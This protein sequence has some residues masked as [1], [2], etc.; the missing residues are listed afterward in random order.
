[1][2]DAGLFAELPAS[3]LER[4][5]GRYRSPSGHWVGVSGRARVIAYNTEVLSAEDLPSSIL[6]FT[7]PKWEGRL[8]WAP[9]NGSFQAWVTALRIAEGE[10]GARAWLEGIRDNGVTA[11]PNNVAIVDAVG[12][13]EIDAGFVNHYYLYRFLAE[14]GEDFPVRNY[15]TAAGDVGT[16]VNVAGAGM[17]AGTDSE[18]E[19]NELLEFLLGTEAQEYLSNEVYE[20]PLVDGINTSIELVPLKTIEPV[21]IELGEL[22]DLEGTLELLQDAGVLP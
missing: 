10:D 7:D 12:R 21:D 3:I 4:V 6:E 14:E 9:P 18:A 1:V 2:Q 19:A 8:G 5:P 17:I 15:F 13:G 11:Y 22:D 20:Y 16:L